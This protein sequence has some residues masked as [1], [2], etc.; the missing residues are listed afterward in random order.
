[1]LKWTPEDMART[2]TVQSSGRVALMAA[3]CGPV[4]KVLHVLGTS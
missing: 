4:T 3:E 2:Y 1:M